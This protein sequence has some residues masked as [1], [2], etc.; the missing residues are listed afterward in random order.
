MQTA[1]RSRRPTALLGLR[2]LHTDLGSCSNI[3][4]AKKHDMAFG[5]IL[6]VMVRNVTILSF[7]ALA[8]L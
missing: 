8:T 4:Y 6:E 2:R 1:F 3:A 5:G 7:L